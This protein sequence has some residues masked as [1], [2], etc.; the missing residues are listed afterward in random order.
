MTTENLAEGIR[1]DR[2]P[3]GEAVALAG[4]AK[5]LRSALAVAQRWHEVATE[6]DEV[7]YLASQAEYT[8]DQLE[9]EL[10]RTCWRMQVLDRRREL[11]QMGAEGPERAD[12]AAVLSDALLGAYCALREAPVEAFSVEAPERDRYAHMGALLVA[13]EAA[14]GEVERAAGKPA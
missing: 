14:E 11:R 4:E 5:R 9:E 2:R 12:E 8:R 3:T 7:G 10:A 6:D 13:Q 1:E